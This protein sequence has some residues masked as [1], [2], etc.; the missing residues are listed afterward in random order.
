[1]LLRLPPNLLHRFY[2]GG[3]E[4]ARFRGIPF[5]DGHA[6]EDWVGSTTTAYGE[7]SVGLSRL[8]DGTL[9]RDVVLRDGL[10]PP[11]RRNVDLLVKLLDA[12]ERLPVHCHPDAAYARERLGSR[13][14]KTE[15]WLIVKTSGANPEVGLGFREEVPLEALADWVRRQ[16]VDALLGSLNRIPVAAGDVVFVP[17][18]LPHAIGQGIFMIEVQ[19]PSDLSILLEWHG[20][21]LGEG[22]DPHLGL[23]LE[24]ALAAVDR[25]AWT[26]DRLGGLRSPTSSGGE[27]LQLLPPDADP[28]FRAERLRPEVELE[29]E[30]S[31]SILVV[32]AGQ[33]LLESAHESLALHAGETAL[34]GYGAG[35]TILS[36]PLDVIRCLPPVSMP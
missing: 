28:F 12:G 26:A 2:R 15:A 25:S 3:E 35:A 13:L 22:A 31:L 29:L 24:E 6:P 32:V 7:H 19:E 1:M 20:F 27:R 33:G 5:R 21:R 17:A 14:G 16:D 36:G 11:G 23:E 8:E 9:L 4:I 10:L 18:G 34:V 30:P